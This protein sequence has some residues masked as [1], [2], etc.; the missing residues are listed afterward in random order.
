MLSQFALTASAFGY[1]LVL[2]AIAYYGDWLRA[3]GRSL[4][5]NPFFY[6]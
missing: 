2:F 6:T 4:I 1:L 5:A 3:Q